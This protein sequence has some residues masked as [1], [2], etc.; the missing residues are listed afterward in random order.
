[1]VTFCSYLPRLLQSFLS[2]LLLL[3]SRLPTRCECISACQPWRECVDLAL[4]QEVSVLSPV[5]PLAHTI[6]DAGRAASHKAKLSLPLCHGVTILLQTVFQPP[7]C[8]GWAVHQRFSHPEEHQRVSR[9]TPRRVSCACGAGK[10]NVRARA[11]GVMIMQQIQ[12]IY[13]GISSVLCISE[14][15]WKVRLGLMERSHSSFSH[16]FTLPPLTQTRG[17]GEGWG[18]HVSQRY[19]IIVAHR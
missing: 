19:L 10:R 5:F 8:R 7:R 2:P 3:C 9:S 6:Q 4:V 16:S 11:R 17:E 18:C 15:L 13:R 12:I 1:M 14:T